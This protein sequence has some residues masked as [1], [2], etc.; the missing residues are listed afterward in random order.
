MPLASNEISLIVSLVIVALWALIKFWKYKIKP[1]PEDVVDM[2]TLLLMG[3]VVAIGIFFMMSAFNLIDL[4]ELSP[5]RVNLGISGAI[6]IGA[7]IY[8]YYVV[9]HRRLQKQIAKVK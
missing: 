6:L 4:S 9:I 1:T 2:I 5:L 3:P 8:I 7:S